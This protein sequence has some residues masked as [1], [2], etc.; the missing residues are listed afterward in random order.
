MTCSRSKAPSEMRRKRIVVALGG[1]AIQHAHEIG[2]FQEQKKNVQ[3]SCGQILQLIYAGYEV[4]L[5]HGNGPQVGNLLIQQ[6][7]GAPEVPEQP[8][9]ACGGMTQGQLG[10]MLQQSL[11]NGLRSCN[12]HLNVVTV[13][14]QVVVDREDKAFGNP[15][16]PI[17]PLYDEETMERYKRERGYSLRRVQPDGEKPFRRVVSSP[18]PVRILEGKA[19]KNLVDSGMIVIAAGGGGIPVAMNEAGEFEGVEAVIDKDLAGEKL[20]EAVAAD[21]FMILTDVDKVKLGYKTPEE[22][23]IDRMTLAEAKQHLKQ[24]QFLPGSMAPKVL[25]CIRFIEYGGTEAIITALD[26]A[27]LSISGPEGTHIVAA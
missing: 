13:V 7:A 19:I 8:M 23:T 22:K 15:T 17:G 10:Y 24:G 21:L 26:K 3:N 12:F 2:T 6:E 9:D 20:A 11:V 16:K 1:N 14:T 5:T 4:I 18:D 27:S 25:A